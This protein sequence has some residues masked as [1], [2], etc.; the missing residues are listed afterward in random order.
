[1]P[2]DMRILTLLHEMKSLQIKALLL[3]KVILAGPRLTFKISIL[4]LVIQGENDHF[5]KMSRDKRKISVLVQRRASL[6]ITGHA[7]LY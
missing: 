5:M 3:Y 7:R 2:V 6:Q 4:F 1:M